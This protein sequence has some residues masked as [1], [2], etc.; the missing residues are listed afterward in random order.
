ML[1]KLILLCFV[2][3]FGITDSEN[4]SD[5]RVQNDRQKVLAF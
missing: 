5:F 4:E 1:S 2:L 3:H